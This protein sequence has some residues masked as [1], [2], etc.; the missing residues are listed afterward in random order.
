MTQKAK[1]L[2]AIYYNR[3]QNANLHFTTFKEGWKTD[4]GMIYVVFGLIYNGV[5]YECEGLTNPYWVM[6]NSL[7]DPAQWLILVLTGVLVVAPRLCVQAWSNTLHPSDLVLA[8]RLDKRT[9]DT[10]H[11]ME[12]VETRNGFV[13]F[14][15]SSSDATVS[16]S[17]ISKVE[18]L[19][20]TEMTNMTTM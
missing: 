14:F 3:I 11:R 10:Q 9:R 13:K 7:T 17:S 18:S 16:V 8:L 5:C 19:N 1:S 6:Q 2:I 12:Q 20:D 4:R 15:R